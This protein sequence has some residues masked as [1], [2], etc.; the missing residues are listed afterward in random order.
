MRID[1][2]VGEAI[3]RL[4]LGT[5][6]RADVLLAQV[7]GSGITRAAAMAAVQEAHQYMTLLALV[8]SGTGVALVPQPVTMLRHDRVRY[9]RLEHPDATTTLTVATRAGDRS[10][11]VRD[12]RTMLLGGDFSLVDETAAAD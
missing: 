2:L 11:I 7:A 10:P 1:D 5:A 4:P 6:R 12:F 8:A 3:D 9:L